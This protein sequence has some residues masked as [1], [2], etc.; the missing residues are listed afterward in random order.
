MVGSLRGE[1]PPVLELTG[2][3]KSFGGTVALDRA[4]LE[5]RSGEIHALVGQNGSGKSTLIKILSGYHH[6][7][8]GRVAALGQE[9]RLPLSSEVLRGF[10]IS[11][12][13]QDL[14]LISGG[15]VLENLRVGRYS[16]GAGK[17]IRWRVE[18][19]LARELLGRFELDVDVD[20]QIA[21]LSQ[22]QRVILAVARAVADVEQG[23]GRGLLVLDE[24]TAALPPHEIGLL[25]TAMRRVTEWG[26]AVLFVTH[27]LDEV[28]AVADRVSVLRDGRLVATEDVSGLDEQSLVALV[29]GRKLGELYPEILLRDIERVMEIRGL[30]GR[31]AEDVSLNLHS[32][33]IV[34]LT[35]LV[36]AGHD[37]VPYLIYGALPPSAGVIAIDGEEW[38]RP[39]PER[40]KQA[41][42]ALLPADR[43]A[44]SGISRATVRE[45][46]TLP[47]LAGYRT[48]LG[49]DLARE[50][51]DVQRDLERFSVQPPE[52]ERLLYTLSGGNQQKAL[53]ARWLRMKPRVLLLHE[54]TQ[55]VDIGARRGI[56]GILR[57][58]VMAG[59]SVLYS[60]VE[61]EDLAN[62]CDRVLVF[63]R[64]IVIR[65]LSGADLTADKIAEYCYRSAEAA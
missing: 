34:G 50:R 43:Q 8:A 9:V 22:T 38:T 36:G 21:R 60:S 57:D 39:T 24:P 31:V 47:A 65:T 12:V 48:R 42:V 25:F 13:H 15:T 46:V 49:L 53:L 2:L 58:S 52:T 17:R 1:E 10:G 26:S 19:A 23:G 18:R 61:Y 5:I 44:Q 54:P 51:A 6:A 55:G 11:F 56:F 7:D 41:G 30:C 4:D 64:G 62:V 16:T 3:S 40:S 14:G 28:L 27:N 33:E 59:T 35:G 63:R 37:E 45:N 32:G 20:E 29:L